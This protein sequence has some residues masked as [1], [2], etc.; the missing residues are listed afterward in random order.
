MTNDER[1]IIKVNIAHYE[2]M[3]KLDIDDERRA[4]VERLLAESKDVLAEDSKEQ[5]RL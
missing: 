4:T 1:Y 5:V 3:L 2:A